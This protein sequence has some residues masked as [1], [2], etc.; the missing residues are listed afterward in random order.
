MNE[1]VYLSQKQNPIT[2]SV[3][4]AGKF[5]KKH[6]HVLR[7]IES[8][9]QD[10]STESTCGFSE[11]EFNSMFFKMSYKD[12]S[13][14]PNPMYIMTKKGFT[15]LAMRFKGKKALVFQLEFINKFDEMEAKLKELCNNTPVHRLVKH[16]K[17]DVQIQNSKEVNTYQYHLGGTKSVADYNRQSCKIHSGYFPSE[18]KRKA[19]SDGV[20][21]K[22]RTS[23]K[24]VLR[25]YKP[26]IAASMSLTDEFVKKGKMLE[27]AAKLCKDCA[28]PLFDEM[29]KLNMISQ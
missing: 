14:K 28:T 26:A 17:R 2:D 1:I 21:S 4:V 10:F 8:I 5:E 6:M 20:P 12:A 7:T 27:P 9:K 13:G 19:K 23:G 11:E 3:K 15:L 25:Y 16:T 18:L 22:H 29:I 24:E